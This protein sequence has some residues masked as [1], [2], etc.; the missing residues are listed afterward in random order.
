MCRL[1]KTRTQTRTKT[2]HK[3]TQGHNQ[4]PKGFV[5]QNWYDGVREWYKFLAPDHVF[6]RGHSRHSWTLNTRGHSW[7][8]VDTRVHKVKPLYGY[9]Y[10]PYR[11]R[12]ERPTRKQVSCTPHPVLSPVVATTCPCAKGYKVEAI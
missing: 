4:N 3:I 1:T 11:P 2:G 10:V 5:G 12:T 7:T 9:L 8:L 6:T